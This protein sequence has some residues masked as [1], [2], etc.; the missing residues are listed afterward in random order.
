M[1]AGVERLPSLSPC[2]LGPLE[3]DVL[4]GT[5]NGEA[6]GES[7]EKRWDRDHEFIMKLCE[8]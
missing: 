3:F 5:V 8:E 7:Q 6:A 2:R 4:I 1:K